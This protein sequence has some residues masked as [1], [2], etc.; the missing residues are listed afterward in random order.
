MNLFPVNSSANDVE[1]LMAAVGDELRQWEGGADAPLDS[2]PADE[3]LLSQARL[4]RLQWNID[5]SAIIHSTRPRL[6]PWLVRF[7]LLVR[8]LTWWFLE[9]IL[10]QVRLF[11]MN[12]ARV[13][14][15]LARRQER[16][17][18]QVEALAAQVEA[19]QR[20]VEE[21]EASRGDDET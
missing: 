11:Q 19:L 7:Q 6:G 15:G 16:L 17:G 21:L 12:A 13:G 5:G 8:R 10:Q 3:A 1:E 20:R 14:E 4:L 9:P 18:Q 2:S